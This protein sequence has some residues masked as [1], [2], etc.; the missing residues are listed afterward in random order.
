MASSL[1]W[2]DYSDQQ[3]RQ[4]LDVIHLF[5]EKTTRDELG[6]GSVR[7]ALADLFFPGTSTIQT[8]ARYFLFVPWMYRDLER[9]RITSADVARKARKREIALIYALLASGDDRGVIGKDS[10]E[11]LQRLPSSI[12][13]NGLA[14]LGIR[15]F[16]GSQEEYHRSLDGFY[17]MVSGRLTNDD[18][19]PEVSAGGNWHTSLPAKPSDFPDQASFEFRKSDAEYLGQR[20]MMMHPRSLFAVLLRE[21]WMVDSVTYAWQHPRRASF[22]AQVREQLEHARNF[23]ESMHGAALLYNLML[24]EAREWKP[25]AERY[26][27]GLA[28]WW[29]TIEERRDELLAWDRRRL[30]EIAVSDGAR[31][32]LP[33]R[34][35]VQAWLEVALKAR[36]HGEIV[37]GE[38]AR[39]L[40]TDREVQLK[41]TLARLTSRR[42]LELWNGSAG[43]DQ[44]DFRWSTAQQMVEDILTPLKARGVNAQPR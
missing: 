15:R 16:H 36:S 6:L 32:G 3:R 9:R 8:R 18:E 1:T 26:D 7:D 37:S 44:L 24:A 29:N 23:S 22:P 5:A 12:Y 40:I 27:E 30:W 21:A 35:F 20:I 2:L 39:Q 10:K 17:R 34:A 31:V 13:W 11:R 28:R 4:M 25:L 19:E 43:A 42:A 41:R 33:T 14:K 38:K